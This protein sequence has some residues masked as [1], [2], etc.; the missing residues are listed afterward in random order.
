M[1][2]RTGHTLV[3]S[4]TWRRACGIIAIAKTFPGSHYPRRAKRYHVRSD[5]SRA[6]GPESLAPGLSNTWQAPLSCLSPKGGLHP[7]GTTTT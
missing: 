3:T 2:Y 1:I 4:C 7:A 6:T 5:I